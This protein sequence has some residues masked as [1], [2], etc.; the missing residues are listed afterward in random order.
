MAMITERTSRFHRPVV[1]LPMMLLRASCSKL[2]GASQR[3]ADT[4]Q[5]SKG[6]RFDHWRCSCVGKALSTWNNPVSMDEN[7]NK[8]AAFCSINIELIISDDL[9]G[10]I[11][12]AKFRLFMYSKLEPKI[13]KIYRNL[14]ISEKP[15]V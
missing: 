6:S 2:K 8:V 14:Y 11:R 10:R 15:R 5:L 4:G 1:R 12:L 9:S 13:N 3:R 7:S